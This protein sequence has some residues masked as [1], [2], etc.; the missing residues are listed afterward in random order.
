MVLVV[1][2][3]GQLGSELR[4]LL[5]DRACY[6]GRAQL[7]IRRQEET[8]DYVRR[9]APK[10]IINAAAYTAVDRA[11]EDEEEACRVNALGAGH[12]AKAALA[13]GATLIHV[14]TDYVF[15]GR[16][17]SPYA[18]TAATRPLNAYGRT[19]LA[20]ERLVLESGATA[21]I[22][23]TAWLYAR[24]GRNFVNTM[25]RLGAE[26]ESV[27]VVNDQIGAP[28]AACDLA[29]ALVQMAPQIE[30]GSCEIY[31]YSNEGTA[32]WYDVAREVMALSKLPC[33]VVPV[34]S[35]SY[36]TAAKRPAYTVLD[37]RKIRER[38]GIAIP[39]WRDSLCRVIGQAAS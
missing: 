13:A 30:A 27:N 6:A 25:R 5:G 24:D 8:L 32:S 11:E 19:K 15:D 33:R 31:H 34:A 3:N 14:S 2:A 22:V 23:R 21:A 17:A 28:T 29:A 20:G 26:R 9:A 4:L 7:D 37:K 39:Q 16:A 1:G 18:E 36:P 38:F 12:L 35:E 10:L